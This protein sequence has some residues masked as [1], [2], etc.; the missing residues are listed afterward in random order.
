MAR[1]WKTFR[2]RIVSRPRRTR[3]LI[4]G[5]EVAVQKEPLQEKEKEP[6][7]EP[8]DDSITGKDTTGA[9]LVDLAGKATTTAIGLA[10]DVLGP[11]LDQVSD[12]MF[13][14]MAEKPFSEVAP[15]LTEELQENAEFIKNVASDPKV[16]AALNESGEAVGDAVNTA[17]V[18]AKPVVDKAVKDTL[19]ALDESGEKATVGVVNT[20][21]NIFKAA[22]AEIP[23]VGGLVDLGFAGA[24]AFNYAAAAARPLIVSGAETLASTVKAVS[25]ARTDISETK[26]K[27]QSATSELTDAIRDVGAVKEKVPMTGGRRK[28]MRT[29]GRISR[30]LERFTRKRK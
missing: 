10:D 21:L 19:E 24:Q 26:N 22:V 6:L 3:K 14:D 8:F 7:Q 23:V 13:G 30:S 25:D 28:A 2:N 27:L 15:Q 1:R 20:G 18:I 17:L 5:G 4:K 12:A 29:A 11:A 16:I 9:K